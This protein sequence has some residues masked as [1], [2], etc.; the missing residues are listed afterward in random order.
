MFEIFL[1]HYFMQFW[2]FIVCILGIPA[3]IILLLF[4]AFL[5]WHLIQEE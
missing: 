5:L 4:I 3:L 2:I 1:D